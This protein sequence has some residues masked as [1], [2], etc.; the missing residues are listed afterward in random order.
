MYNSYKCVYVYVYHHCI[1]MSCVIF[2]GLFTICY[3]KI[4][5]FDELIVY[6]LGPSRQKSY[7]TILFLLG[8]SVN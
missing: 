7:E 5:V 6:T 4:Y 8:K 1:S 2:T 3:L